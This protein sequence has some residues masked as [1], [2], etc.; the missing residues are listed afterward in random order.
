VAYTL[1]DENENDRPWMTLSDNQYAR[2][3]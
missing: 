2:L 3:F 1:S